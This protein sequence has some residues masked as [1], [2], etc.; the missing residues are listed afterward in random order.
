M[1]V[2]PTRRPLAIA[3]HK[4]GESTVEIGGHYLGAIL[5]LDPYLRRE[6]LIK[7]GLRFF[8]G[9]PEGALA[10]RCEM[11]PQ[12]SPSVPS[13]QLDRGA[14][15]TELRARCDAA[16]IELREGVGVRSVTIGDPHVVEIVETRGGGTPKGVEARWVVDATGRR[17][18]L[19]KSLGLHSPIEEQ[20][21]SSWFRVNE[22]IRVEQLVPA[23]ES[24]WHDKDIDGNRWLSTNHLC[25]EGY[26]V[27]IIPLASGHT[28]IGIVAEASVHPFNTFGSRDATLRWIKAHE[29]ALAARLEGVPWAD[30]IAM[31]DYRHSASQVFS[32]ERWACVGEAGIFI[33]P[34]YS[35][36]SDL[37]GL[38]NTLTAELIGDDFEGGLDPSRA[39]SAD[40]FYR[41]WASLLARTMIGGSRV[42]G[43]PEVFAAKLHWDFF[44]Y[45]AFMCPY[46][47]RRCWA[48]GVAEH[49]RF[50]SMLER[51]TELN[52]RAQQILQAWAPLAPPASTR[53]F[54]GLPAVATTL[55]DLHLALH[56][57]LDTDETYAAMQGSLEWGEHIVTELLLRGLRRAGP[58]GAA[59]FVQAAFP[60]G[61][62]AGVAPSE[63]RLDADE[64]GPR[65]RRK[66]LSK[67]V[68]DMERSVGKNLRAEGPSLRELWACATGPRA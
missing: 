42:F 44:Y 63:E 60:E 1:V 25:G 14:L 6:H 45:W 21:G 27:W 24:Q 3:C 66:L 39:A 41:G 33:D 8:S 54:V 37:I 59:A 28:S 57:E 13:Y 52:E 35:P 38:A 48:L 49:E 34:L 7:N 53:S 67:A 62:D 15:E 61:V 20:A 55:S 40:R 29:P 58:G 11:G 23:E 2:E 32:A 65:A 22:R 43:A 68:R 4:V 10:E 18:L 36:G 56:E 19:A 12:E 16:N 17:R 31:K 30:F 64:A 47:F 9:V 26:W 46:F 5:G 51:Y 50:D